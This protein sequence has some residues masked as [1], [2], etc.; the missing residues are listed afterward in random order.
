MPDVHEFFTRQHE[1]L[2]RARDIDR[3]DADRA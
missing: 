1:H 3:Q 2:N